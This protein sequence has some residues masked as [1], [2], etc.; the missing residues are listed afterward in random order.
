LIDRDIADA[1]TRDVV[2]ELLVLNFGKRA[3]GA[4]AIEPAPIEND[5]LGVLRSVL[6]TLIAHGQTTV[7]SQI[8]IEALLDQLSVPRAAIPSP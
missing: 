4:V 1:V 3:R 2:D 6:N 5:A 7:G 8:N